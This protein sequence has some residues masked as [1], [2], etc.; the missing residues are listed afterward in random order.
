MYQPSLKGD[1]IVATQQGLIF[2][3]F[4][5]IGFLKNRI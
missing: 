2:L 3:L 4:K 1:Y 5:F